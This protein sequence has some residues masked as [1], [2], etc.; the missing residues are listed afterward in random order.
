[1]ETIKNIT[2]VAT[3]KTD[4]YW[5]EMESYRVYSHKQ[6]IHLQSISV[7]LADSAQ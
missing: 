4:G 3:Q 2:F 5:G 6:Y 7:Q 1:M